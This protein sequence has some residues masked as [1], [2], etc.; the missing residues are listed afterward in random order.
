[1]TLVLFYLSLAQEKVLSGLLFVFLGFPPC[2]PS[3]VSVHVSAHVCMCV[4]LCLAVVVRPLGGSSRFLTQGMAQRQ[5][6]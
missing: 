4:S 2:A 5:R 6:A 1:M 3:C